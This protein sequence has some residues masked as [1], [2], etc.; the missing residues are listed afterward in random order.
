MWLS[1]CIK[2][3]AKLEMI[4]MIV[5]PKFERIPNR[6]L[7]LPNKTFRKTN[8]SIMGAPTVIA[9]TKNGL[10]FARVTNVAVFA[11]AGFCPRI[12]VT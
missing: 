10:I 11:E 8:S 3:N 12:K 7:K 5:K 6:V 9:N 2:A 1:L 4:A